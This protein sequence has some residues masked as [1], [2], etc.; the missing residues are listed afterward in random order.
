M[1]LACTMTRAF[2]LAQA[3]ADQAEQAHAGVGHVGLEPHLAVGEDQEQ[4]DQEEE[5]RHTADKVQPDVVGHA[6]EL[7][8]ELSGHV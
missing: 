5:R 4:E 3:H 2:D 6:I 1:I 7:S 8:E